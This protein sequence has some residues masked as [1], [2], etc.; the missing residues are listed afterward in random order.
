MGRELLE[1][2]KEAAASEERSFSKTLGVG[3]MVAGLA[4]LSLAVY[5]I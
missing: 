1:D 3:E 5:L 4:F 2:L